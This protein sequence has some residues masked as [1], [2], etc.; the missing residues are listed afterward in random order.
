M[1]PILQPEQVDSSSSDSFVGESPN[2][3]FLE[4]GLKDYEVNPEVNCPVQDHSIA[5]TVSGR[6]LPTSI[7][8]VVANDMSIVSR[9]WADDESEEVTSPSLLESDKVEEL[10]FEEVVSKSQKKCLK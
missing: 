5:D 3:E 9:F 1:E 10:H 6:K 2:A 7:P 4:A 8:N